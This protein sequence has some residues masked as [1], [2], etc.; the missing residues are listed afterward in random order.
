[1]QEKLEHV[2]LAEHAVSRKLDTRSALRDRRVATVGISAY[3]SWRA[4]GTL[5]ADERWHIDELAVAIFRNLPDAGRAEL[6]RATRARAV[7][8]ELAS[9]LTKSTAAVCAAIAAAPIP[10]ADIVPLTALQAGLVAGIAWI[11]GRSLD[12]RGS[13]EFM[14]GLGANVGIAF[15]LREAVRAIMKVIAPG[16][17]PIISATIAF[18]GTMAIGTAARA[19]FIRG[20]SLEDA[21]RIFRRKKE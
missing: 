3:M 18:S 7:Q 20:A 14:A 17:G 2:T 13:G 19:Y 1:V 16:G 5:R 21:R 4:D 10:V 11:G 6:A 15:G 12:R 8:D 9:T